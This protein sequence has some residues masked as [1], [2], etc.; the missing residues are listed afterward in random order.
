ME[1][2]SN[3]KK[4]CSDQVQQLQTEPDM[5]QQNA[6][7]ISNRESPRAYVHGKEIQPVHSEGDQPWD[8]FGRNDAEA[9]TA[10]LWPP[11]VKSWLIGEVL[12]Q[13]LRAPL[14]VILI[15]VKLIEEKNE[16]KILEQGETD[17]KFVERE[18]SCPEMLYAS[19]SQAN[20]EH[21]SSILSSA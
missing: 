6:K 14:I 12:E 20:P 9:E 13:E 19:F 7:A 21:G 4:I 11:H 10:V 18:S 16:S 5:K 8:F 2:Y 15:K 3:G 1:N 17:P